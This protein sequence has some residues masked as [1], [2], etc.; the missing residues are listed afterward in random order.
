MKAPKFFILV[1]CVFNTSLSS[2]QSS[3]DSVNTLRPV[4]I[5][6]SRLTEYAVGAYELPLDSTTLALSSNGSLAELLRKQGFG[7]IR[8]YGPGGL[9]SPSFRGSG[10]SHTAVLWN[11]INLV[12]PLSGQLDLSLLPSGLFDDVAIQT[13]GSSSLS[14]NG[15]IGG[16]IHLNNAATFNEGLRASIGSTFGSFGN[17][18]YS[19]GIRFSNKQFGSST[20][21]FLNDT[22]NDFRFVNRNIFPAEV[23]RRQHSGFEQR[24][25]LQELHLQTQNAGIFSAKFWYQKSRYE[26]PNATTIRRVSEATERNEFYRSLATWNFSTGIFDF[27]YQGAHILQNLDYADPRTNLYSSSTYKSVVQNAELQIRFSD[28]T[29]LTSGIHYSW[30]KGMVREFGSA[31]PTRNRVALF[32]AYKRS[33]SQRL[34]LALSGREEIVNGTATP[35]A[36]SLA[37]QY[38]MSERIEVFAKLSRNYRL[39]TFNDLYWKGGSTRG[40]PEI[41]AEKSL[42]AEGG[43]S[44]NGNHTSMK[45]A[46]FSNLVDDWIQWTPTEGQ[47]WMPQN[48]KQVWSRGIESQ[49]SIHGSLGV[50]KGN[51]SGQY[52]F[53]KSTNQ[54][55]HAGGNPN[56]RGKQ[57]IL[58]PIHQGSL[59]AEADWRK[60]TL[61]LVNSYTGEQF[62]DSDNTPYNIVKDYLITNLWLSKQCALKDF[63]FL[64]TGEV[65]N[66]FDVEYEG[67]P[68]F[69]LPGINYKASIQ[70]NF[71]K[72]NR[73]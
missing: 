43:F 67:R 60:Y 38:R 29:Q 63:R 70:I 33:A 18:F 27:S 50:V 41:K 54:S 1:L 61:R 40:N 25:A 16:N 7:N 8:S 26:I 2:G 12:S 58:T 4:L 42:S 71:N 17:Q 49:A 24:G 53:T 45:V 35:F 23:Q 5:T 13:G 14:G 19:A 36:P 21:L 48:L 32:A 47:A 51:L 73:I 15:S 59:T 52:S 30:E 66:L 3:K 46:A 6:Q 44:V 37:T 28:R 64:F 20:K 72:P 56:E 65:N 39:P 22:E 9:T 62:N 10:S 55:I 34:T 57:L 31:D 11:G 68:G 69:P